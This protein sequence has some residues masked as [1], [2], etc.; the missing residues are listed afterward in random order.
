[1]SSAIRTPY[2]L[3]S[4]QH[5]RVDE[6]IMLYHNL[7]EITAEEEKDVIFFLQTEYE[8]E[9]LEYPYDV[10]KFDERAALW[11]AKT[12]Y[13]A[14]QLVLYRENK[15]DD[16]PGLFP[17]YVGEITPGAILSADL[18]LRFLPSI[19][20]QLSF[21]DAEDKLSDILEEHLKTWHYSC[22][23]FPQEIDA[24]KFD[25]IANNKCLYLLY[26]NRV[27]QRKDIKRTESEIIKKGVQASL[28]NYAAEYWKEFNIHTH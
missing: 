19:V 26:T 13:L 21:M 25:M 20:I 8:N 23:G 14:A 4:L 12:V 24:M 9:S 18:C 2:F 16:L 27:I 28:G 15:P 10:P 1:M 17:E 11:A 22:I 5:L 7:L 3:Q 6:C